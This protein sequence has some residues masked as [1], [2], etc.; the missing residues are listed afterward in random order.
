MPW[1]REI[2][3]TIKKQRKY[4]SFFEGPDKDIKEL[5]VLK[6][7]FESMSKTHSCPYKNPLSSTKDPPDCI[8]DDT[9][10]N[11]IGFEI[12]ELVDER[13]VRQGQ[14]GQQELKIWENEELIEKLKEIVCEKDK[15]EYHG[16]PYFKIVLVIFTD[17]FCLDPETIIPVVYNH[18]FPETYQINEVYFLFSY[19]PR[20]HTYPYVK[21]NISPNKKRGADGE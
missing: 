4:A 16:G 21:L 15:K 18:T 11:K 10:G 19:D 14:R 12:S 2:I 8:A 20:I 1:L 13:S 6:L 17:E 9:N 5:W 7:L 3:K